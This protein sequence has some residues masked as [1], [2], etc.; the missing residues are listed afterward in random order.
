LR[1]SGALGAS[2]ILG[3][4]A[5]TS[6]TGA[7]MSGTGALSPVPALKKGDVIAVIAPA[8]A[9]NDKAEQAAAWIAA[10]G[11]SPRIYPSAQLASDDYLAGSD[12]QRL[13]DLHAV[14]ADREVNAIICMRGGY[15][16]ARLLDKI[17][18]DLLRRNPKILVGYS[19]ITALH[20]AIARRAG[21]VTFHGPM[22]SSDFL[23]NKQAPTEE[24]LFAMLRGDVPGGSVISHPERF[25]LQTVHGGVASGRLAGGNLAIIGSMLGTPYEIDLENTIL[26]IEDAGET[27]QK[28]DRLL[29]QLRLAG[30]LSTVRGVL[31]GDFSEIND[32]TDTVDNTVL[33]TQRIDALWRQM[34]E[35]L[36]VPVLAGW[37]SG[38]CDPNLTLPLG[39]LVTLDAGRQQ[40]RLDQSAVR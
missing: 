12:A 34:L 10:R 36:N 40:L 33:N 26:F 15:G 35:P 39:A 21:F 6:G 3:A 8:S 38:H 20:I 14:F 30:K 17:D 24:A 32:P 19:D 31:I 9:A 37:R 23:A 7:A 11:Y 28:I 27:P 29:T 2:G 4:C 22:L 16:C 18:Y 13:T 1:Q 5:S 25:P